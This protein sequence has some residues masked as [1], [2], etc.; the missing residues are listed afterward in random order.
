MRKPSSG[1]RDGGTGRL[2]RPT[3]FEKLESRLLLTGDAAGEVCCATAN[4]TDTPVPSL[5]D[6]GETFATA[7]NLGTVE[8]SPMVQ[9]WVGWW[10]RR[11]VMRFSV[12]E[13]S[14][15]DIAL[16]DLA[17][18][19]DLLLYDGRGREVAISDQP[20]ARSESIQA[21][22]EPGTF[23][24]A[25]DPWY[26]AASRYTL[27]LEGEPVNPPVESPPE[28][29]PEVPDFGGSNEWNLNAVN[30]PAAWEAGYT[31][32]AV[33]VA[34]V[35][36]GVDLDHPDLR[37]NIWENSSEIAG[38]GI[39]DDQNGFVDDVRGWDFAAGDNEPDDANGHGTHVAGTIA[40]SLNG[41]GATGVAPDASVMPIRVLDAQGVG[42]G[43]D[44][45]SGIRYAADNGADIINLS[46]GGAF[47][48]TIWSAVQYAG[49]LGSVVVAAA[50]NEGANAP[51]YPA[52]FSAGSS[53]VISAGGHSASDQIA[54]FSNKV[55]HS[56][57][58]Q[59][60][61]PGVDVFS[62]Y[63][64]GGYATLN[65]TSMAAP[66]VAGVAA[67]TLSANP[68]LTAPQL[69]TLIADGAQRTITGS[70]SVGGI[71]AATTV[72]MA[73]TGETGQTSSASGNGFFPFLGQWQWGVT[74]VSIVSRGSVVAGHALAGSISRA[75]SDFAANRMASEPALSLPAELVPAA[76]P[77]RLRPK[78]VDLAMS[79]LVQRDRF[80]ERLRDGV[81][82][83]VSVTPAADA[84]LAEIGL[85]DRIGWSGASDV[86]SML[87]GGG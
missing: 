18:D 55:G 9:G 26:G 66:H 45:A 68:Q 6:A 72:A 36:T 57:A 27:A 74:H 22:L 38:N 13:E 62:T 59:V 49:Q 79:E 61:G 83:S 75:T 76:Q 19:L 16:E 33:T 56:E 67:L 82:D 69:R 40:A 2:R 11:D 43:S 64:D 17:A 81:T 4:G 31:G 52:G 51:T 25:V 35:D 23:Y 86:A 46:F 30:A 7:Y 42:S 14:E 54:G 12:G 85:H 58:V 3:M 34:V 70:D 39:D 29:L 20:A 47:S 1:N 53:H 65:G 15:V 41:F 44:V 28:R 60:D 8:Q 10:D 63:V 80:G 87:V 78:P 73:A 32:D 24:L 5:A 48:S 50:G 77:S 21:T 71:D 84:L 37:S